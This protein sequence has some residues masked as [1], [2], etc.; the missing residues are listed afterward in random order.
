MILAQ[1]EYLFRFIATGNSG[2]IVF[3]CEKSCKKADKRTENRASNVHNAIYSHS[4]FNCLHSYR[5][6]DEVKDIRQNVDPISSFRDRLIEAG[7]FDKQEIKVG[8][9]L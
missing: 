4:L 6:R 1:G 7:M 9:R 8:C 5:S 3:R 2:K